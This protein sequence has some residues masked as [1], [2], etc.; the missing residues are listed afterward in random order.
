MQD[1]K[2]GLMLGAVIAALALGAFGGWLLGASAATATSSDHPD[3]S[4]ADGD[5]APG[6]LVLLV[7]Q[8]AD[9]LHQLRTAQ[10]AAPTAS[11]ARETVTDATPGAA[12]PPFAPGDRLAAA[13]DR[14][15]TLLE[16]RPASGS[17]P[18]PPS[19]SASAAPRPDNIAA[20]FRLER[21]SRARAHFF[22]TYQRMLDHYGP[23]ERMESSSSGTL[24][25]IYRDASSE[26]EMGFVFFDG[27]VIDA[28]G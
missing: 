18:A 7:R 1:M 6:E 2:V 16:Q 21:E 4:S 13:L 10:S 25:W 9:E 19:M 24:I 15:A 17:S 26:R 12:T 20:A 23:P 28:W 11:P 5:R 14:L 8:I 22:W 3:R 27:F